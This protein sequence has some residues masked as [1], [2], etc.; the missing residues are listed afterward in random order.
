MSTA[1]A[2]FAACE[3]AVENEVRTSRAQNDK[4]F[5]FQNWVRARIVE[6]GHSISGEGRN[7]YPDFEIEAHD[8]AFEVKGI[9]VGSRENDFDS[10]S[11]LPSGEYK[12]KR[13]FYVFGRYESVLHGG[14][15]PNVLDV[16]IADGTFLNAGPGFL[17]DNKSLRVLGSYGD[18][19]F[20]DRKM[21]A[22]HT[23]YKLLSGLRGHCTLIMPASERPPAAG[24]VEVGRFSRTEA[25]RVLTAYHGDLKA[26]TLV[27]DFDANLTGGME[28]PFVAYRT[29]RGN[30]TVGVEL[31]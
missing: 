9:T 1:W 24:F 2:I 3:S 23:P 22:P 20:R 7:R 26:N 21:Y 10:N 5:H 6:S 12:G 28:H 15:A 29:V 14:D 18:I 30:T 31:I 11:A 25:D 4:E 8:E 13:V 19:L 27:G 16:V 17:A